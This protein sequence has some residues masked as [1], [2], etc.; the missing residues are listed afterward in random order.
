MQTRRHFLQSSLPW[1]LAAFSGRVFAQESA[2]APRGRLSDNA[3]IVGASVSAG[4]CLEEP[5]GGKKSDQYALKHHL[6]A[7]FA[8]EGAKVSSAAN[9]LLFM[10]TQEGVKPMMAKVKA[11]KPTLAVGV[12]FL[13]W[14]CYGRVKDEAERLAKL[15]TGLALAAEFTGEVVLGDLPDA[16]AAAAGKGSMLSPS[17][18]PKP[19]TLAAANARL[20]EWAKARPNVSILPVSQ[21]MASSLAD[22]AIRIG[23]LELPA[24]STARLLQA[25]KL[26]CGRRGCSALA[27]SVL[28]LLVE[29]GVL[30]K[31]EVR[32]DLDAVYAA[33]IARAKGGVP[34]TSPTQ[35]SEV[36]P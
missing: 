4:F 19:E 34:E 17:Q 25:D 29:K 15:E 33:A 26:H 24:G 8:A 7:A 12:D 16:S 35:K 10:N 13:F 36:S 30:E 22:A 5:L 6:A 11:L 28:N 14:H 27:I 9:R 1:T 2:P 23:P 3:L 21:F 20:R 31:S 32:W 18:V